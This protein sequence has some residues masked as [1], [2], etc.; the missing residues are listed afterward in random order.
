MATRGAVSGAAS[1]NAGVALR[2]VGTALESVEDVV[3]NPQLLSGRNPAQ[4]QGLIGRTPG[5]K[6]EGLGK[7]SRE[8]QGWLLR[9]YT[10]RGQPTG[11]MIRWHPG[12]GHHGPDPYW[13]VTGGSYGKSEIIR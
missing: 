2:R 12:G 7:G 4:V 8:G 11:R 5:W 9:E 10:E 13:R 1:E 6:V 3:A